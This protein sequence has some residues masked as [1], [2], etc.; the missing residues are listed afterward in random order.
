MKLYNSIVFHHNFYDH[1]LALNKN[2]NKIIIIGAYVTNKTYKNN[3]PLTRAYQNI[4]RIDN[5]YHPT[6]VFNHNWIWNY[7]YNNKW[8]VSI[9]L[10]A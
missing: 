4:V 3:T 2:K 10:Q 6:D 5:N 1:K 8:S 7:M 9:Q